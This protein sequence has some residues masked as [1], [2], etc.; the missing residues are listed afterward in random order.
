[1]EKLKYPIGRFTKP[2]RFSPELLNDF[3]S[4]IELFHAKLKAEVLFLSDE[5]LDTPYRPD[6]WTV[7]QVVNHCADSHM[8]ALIRVKLAITEDSPTISAYKQELWAEL[9]DSKQM[10][11]APALQIIEGVH[12]RWTIILKS[13]L[14][15]DWQKSYIHPEKG[16]AVSIEEAT[17][18]YAWHCEHHLGHVLALKKRLGW[19]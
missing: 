12:A 8:N 16:R 3:I 10:P 1:M 5:Q 19:K 9:A 11:I 6:G 18:N 2:E 4:V 14:Q 7:R 17:A 15:K 13:C